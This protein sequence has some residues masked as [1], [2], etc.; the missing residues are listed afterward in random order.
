MTHNYCDPQFWFYWHR[1]YVQFSLVVYEV[2]FALFNHS[3]L[4]GLKTD[5]RQ[6]W[7]MYKIIR[8]ASEKKEIHLQD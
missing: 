4:K 6:T 8:N 3:H 1:F 2:G 5:T 7:I